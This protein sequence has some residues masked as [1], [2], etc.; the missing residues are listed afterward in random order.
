V[1]AEHERAGVGERGEQRAAGRLRLYGVDVHAAADAR[2]RQLNRMMDAVPGD[3]GRG[4]S[5]TH[6]D[7]DVTGGV[8]RGGH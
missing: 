8:P 2:V 4:V 6:L 7:G 5:A 1:G 3:Q